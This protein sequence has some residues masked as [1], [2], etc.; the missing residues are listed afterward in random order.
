MHGLF[1]PDS[2]CRRIRYTDCTGTDFFKK[3]DGFVDPLSR[4]IASIPEAPPNQKMPFTKGYGK[5]LLTVSRS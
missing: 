2:L 4:S 1:L 5:L 3:G